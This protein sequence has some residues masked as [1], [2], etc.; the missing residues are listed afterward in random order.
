MDYSAD[1]KY[2]RETEERH[3]SLVES[4]SFISISDILF[5]LRSNWYWFIITLV[6]SLS[7]AGV[8]LLRTPNVYSRRA[9][10]L[11]KE[12]PDATNVLNDLFAGAGMGSVGG[13]KSAVE[14]ELIILKTDF[15]IE[16]VIDKLNLE[17]AYYQKDLFTK[18]N[19]NGDCPIS[20]RFLEGLENISCHLEV[21]SKG[22]GLLELYCSDASD[23]ALEGFRVEGELGNPIKTPKGAILVTATKSTPLTDGESIEVVKSSRE[24]CIHAYSKAYKVSAASK[25]SSIIDLEFQHQSPKIAEDFLNGIIEVYNNNSRQE[26][27]KIAEQTE[28]FIDDRLAVIGGELGNVDNEIEQFKQNNRIADISREAQSYITG[29]AELTRQMTEVNNKL[30]VANYLKDYLQ[31]S[32]SK[33]ELIPAN[34]GLNDP[35]AENLIR[36]YNSMLLDAP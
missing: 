8:Y 10:I 33:S 32:K 28:R 7:I 17:V 27:V 30:A 9:S 34:V 21:V 24:V 14:N 12:K 15:L 18:K 6:I 3:S 36:E 5:I 26:K 35:S 25:Q 4:P 1:H 2:P 23:G 31:A 11:I 19:L 22:G 13:V 20:V 16:Q 29:S